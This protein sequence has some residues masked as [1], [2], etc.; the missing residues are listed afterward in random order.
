MGIRRGE[1]TTKIISDGLVFN[2]DAANRACYIPNANTTFNTINLSNSGSLE[3]GTL[4]SNNNLGVFEFDGSDDYINVSNFTELSN[5]SQASISLW[6]NRDT[7]QNLVLMDLKDGSNGRL[8]LQSYLS[9]TLYIY[10]NGKSYNIS[11]SPSTS[12]NNWYNMVLVYNGSGSTN[13]DKL[14]LYLNSIEQTGGS[15]SGTV[16]S[17]IGSFGVNT[18]FEIGRTPTTAHFNGEINLIHIYN[19][20][21]SAEE[22]LYN[23]NGLR[24]RFGV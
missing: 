8:A 24:G 10:L 7:D 17:S 11:P 2:I 5:L 14:K 9:N 20:A 19:R 23:Y 12:T 18:Y 16:D 4:F 13:A 15:Y 22:I 21:L 3:N 6:F 1:I